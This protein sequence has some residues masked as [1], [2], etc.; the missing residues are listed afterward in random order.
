ML[1]KYLRRGMSSLNANDIIHG[2]RSQPRSGHDPQRVGPTRDSG[3]RPMSP[4]KR[5]ELPSHTICVAFQKMR[6]FLVGRETGDVPSGRDHI[7]AIINRWNPRQQ[8]VFDQ[9][10]LPTAPQPPARRLSRGA[11]YE[12]LQPLLIVPAAGPDLQYLCDALVA[13]VCQGCRNRLGM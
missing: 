7:L 5:L 1:W 4:R 10:H 8:T 12:A 3:A 13:Q 6:R 2:A 11:E 9:A